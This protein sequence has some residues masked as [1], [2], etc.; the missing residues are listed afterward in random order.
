MKLTKH[1]LTL[2]LKGITTFRF[3]LKKFHAYSLLELEMYLSSVPLKQLEGWSKD[4]KMI[5]TSVPLIRRMVDFVHQKRRH[6]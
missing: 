3:L 5:E 4:L 6:E 1:E 2:A